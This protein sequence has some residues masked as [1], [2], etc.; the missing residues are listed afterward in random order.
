MNAAQ[1][2]RAIREDISNTLKQVMLLAADN[3]ANSTPVDTGHATTN[4][5]LSTGT[6]YNGIAGSREAV[7]FAERE[8]GIAALQDYD[9]VRD[10][11]IYLRNNVLY[12]QYLDKGSS[13]Q[14][15][16]GFVGAALQSATRRAPHG[17][18]TAV[19]KMLRNMTRDAYRKGL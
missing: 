15:D 10:G 5:I 6:P 13:Q 12:I 8:A 7:S 18:K 19:R 9:V 3:V 11:P 17:R 1:I 4:W 14:A 16:P 2:G